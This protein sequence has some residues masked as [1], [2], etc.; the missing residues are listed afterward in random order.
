MGRLILFFLTWLLPTSLL[1]QSDTLPE[2]PYDIREHFSGKKGKWNFSGERLYKD[3]SIYY[4]SVYG[5]VFGDTC[6]YYLEKKWYYPNGDIKRHI[7]V[8]FKNR[9]RA[10][11]VDKS[12]SE[13]GELVNDLLL[14]ARR[15]PEQNNPKKVDWGEKNE[16]TVPNTR[17]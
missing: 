12:Y 9:R 2:F 11:I 3:S 1:A 6:V 5:S 4:F 10:K 13:K 17:N 8:D 15:K 16:T 14:K 7:Y